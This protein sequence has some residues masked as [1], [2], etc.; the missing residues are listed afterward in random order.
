MNVPTASRNAGLDAACEAFLAAY[1]EYEATR[2]LDELRAK[3][4]ARLDEQG[5]VYL[6]YTGSGL[7][8]AS[9]IRRHS[10]MLLGKVLGN[11]H[12]S[13]PTSVESTQLLERCRHRILD[14]FHA[15]PGEYAVVFTANASQALKLVGES[16][17]FQAGDQFLLTFDNHNS[18]NG[19]REFDRAR[20]AFTLYVPM[21]PP[22]LRVDDSILLGHLG[23]ID[24]R[25]NNLFAYPA[26]SNFSGVR[27]PLGWVAQATERGWSVLLDAAAFVPSNRLDL[28]QVKPDFVALS[29][30]KMFGYPTGV[31][32]L[33]ARTEALGR[34]HRPWFAG[35]TIN[36]A[37]VQADRFVLAPG[38]AAFEDGTLDFASI[39]AVELGLDLLDSVGIETIHQRVRLLTAWLIEQML[40]L[41][42]GN[43]RPLVRLYGPTSTDRRGGT[44]AFN[45]QDAR[46]QVIDHQL[47]EAR[48]A[49]R[50][51][52]LRTGCFCNPGAGELALGLTRDELTHCFTDSPGHMSYEDLR[53]CVD[54]HASGAVRVSLGVASNFADAFAFQQFAREFLEG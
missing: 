2:S 54:P 46:G 25:R 53:R 34:L 31:G 33:I 24:R 30:Y 45:L 23:A 47:V 18:V 40:G 4:F 41:V 36:V 44:L 43:G 48:A 22:D 42:H 10:E 14:F 29:F 9:Q 7:Y 32:A 6:D 8:A 28:A 3:E 39:P 52:S 15:D 27:H 13:N 12:S 11:P 26:Q 5:H 19:I 17:P 51:I 1:P 16:F 49:A 37:S 21:V 35:G 38:A 20:G 50:R